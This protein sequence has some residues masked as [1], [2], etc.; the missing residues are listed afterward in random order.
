MWYSDVGDGGDI[1]LSRMTRY[2]EESFEQRFEGGR[3]ECHVNV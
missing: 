3:G 1:V 2:E